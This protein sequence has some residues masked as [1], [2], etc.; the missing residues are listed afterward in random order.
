[1]A[2]V[3]R[4]SEFREPVL[5]WQIP[6]TFRHYVLRLGFDAALAETPRGRLV[7]Y[8]RNAATDDAKLMVYDIFFKDLVPLKREAERRAELLEEAKAKGDHGLLPACPS[9]MFRFCEYK[10]RCGCGA[11]ES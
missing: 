8:Y 4:V 9:W 3:V 7:V 2:T 11:V 6:D 1:V 10:D 5:R